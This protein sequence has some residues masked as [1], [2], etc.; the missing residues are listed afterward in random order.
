MQYHCIPDYKQLWDLLFSPFPVMCKWKRLPKTASTILPILI[1]FITS[2][3]HA[4]LPCFSCLFTLFE[5]TLAFIFFQLFYILF[6]ENFFPSK[7]FNYQIS[8]LKGPASYSNP[9]LQHRPFFQAPNTYLHWALPGLVT[10]AKLSSFSYSKQV[11]LY[12]YNCYWLETQPLFSCFFH[13]Q[14]A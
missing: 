14:M 4:Q 13:F 3:L 6:L 11:S 12:N 1:A 10:K 9:I 7:A 5:Q 2:L 8:Y